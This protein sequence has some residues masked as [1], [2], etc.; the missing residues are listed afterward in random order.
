MWAAVLCPLPARF[1]DDHLSS[2]L[3]KLHPEP[4]VLE[5]DHDGALWEGLQAGGRKGLTRRFHVCREKRDGD[6]R[7]TGGD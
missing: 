1:G 3:V 5:G 2:Y 4:H 6:C 7:Q